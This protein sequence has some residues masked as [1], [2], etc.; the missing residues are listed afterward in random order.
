MN[1]GPGAT[2]TTG[3]VLNDDPARLLI[4]SDENSSGSFIYNNTNS[5]EPHATVEVWVG[6][7]EQ[8]HLISPTTTNTTS[9]D[10][11]SDGTQPVG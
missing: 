4:R 6:E 11:F 9:A 10:F 7:T 1:I 3:E 2:V 5:P 8:W